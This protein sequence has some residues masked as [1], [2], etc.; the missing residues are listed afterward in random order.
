MIVQLDHK[1][2]LVTGGAG[3][4]G[5][6][7]CQALV[8]KGSQV[9]IVDNLSNGSMNNLADI[10]HQVNFIKMDICSSAFTSL[11]VEANFD[12]IFHLAANAYVPPSVKD[13]EYDFQLNLVAPF[14][15]LE[16]IRYSGLNPTLVVN[17]SAGVYGNPIRVPISETD[18]A[19]P[20]S[21]YGVSKL[22]MERYVYVFS[23]LY[24]IKAA[25]LRLFSVYGPRQCKQIVYDF[26]RKITNNPASL[27]ILGDGTQVR[28]FVYVEDVV[29]ALLVVYEQAPLRGEVYN[30]ASGV[31]YSTRDLAEIIFKIIG[32]EP[33]YYFSGSIRPGDP[34]VWIANIDRIQKLGYSPKFSLEE[35]IRRTIE[36]YRSSQ[37]S[38]RDTVNV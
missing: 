15:L 32:L 24:G 12:V 11:L 25:S 10:E 34:D 9:T 29:Q 19:I 28:D 20:I 38:T 23:Q 7:L 1:S 36:W 13:P 4:I 30:L 18:S 26:I 31:S 6:H 14:R 37:E 22:A 16:T 17:S 2:V 27:E 21:P 8:R 5:S 35:G 3:F 33:N